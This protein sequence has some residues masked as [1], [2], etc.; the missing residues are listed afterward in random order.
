MQ[1]DSAYN[2]VVV[3]EG[4]R[5]S[6]PFEVRPNGD[7]FDFGR[8]ASEFD[9]ES[10]RVRVEAE[11]VVKEAPHLQVK[12]TFRLTEHRQKIISCPFECAHV[13]GDRERHLRLDDALC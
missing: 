9:E 2:E 3:S 13:A 4:V 11:D 5:V 7:F 10:L 8:F 1:E 6:M 12:E